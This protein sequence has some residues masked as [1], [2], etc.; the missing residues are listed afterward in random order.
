ME[1]VVVT[2]ERSHNNYCAFLEKLPGCTSGGDTFDELKENI[3]EAVEG[4]V[5]ISREYGDSLKGF[6]TGEYEFDFRFHTGSLLQFYEEVFAHSTLE[7][8]TRIKERRLQRYAAGLSR[9]RKEQSQILV[10]ALHKLGGDLLAV[11]L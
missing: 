8:A 11:K 10:K 4:H 7:R 6:P 9:P 3:A 5:E 1:K 2:V